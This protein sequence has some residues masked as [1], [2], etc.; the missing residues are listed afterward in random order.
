MNREQRKKN[1]ENSERRTKEEGFL[2]FSL[3]IV[4]CSLLLTHFSFFPF[5]FS[6]ANN[7]TPRSRKKEE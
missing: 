6:F 7:P 3:L 5:H 1:S 2:P 4:Y